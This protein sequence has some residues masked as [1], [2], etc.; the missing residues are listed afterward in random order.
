MQNDEIA[1]RLTSI[2]ATQSALQEALADNTRLTAQLLLAF[3]AGDTDG[4]RRYHESVIE[5]RELRN[6]VVRECLMKAATATT[7]G[8]LGWVAF[9]I[10]KA[11]LITVKQ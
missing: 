2:Q 3:P 9:A 7:L 11:L 1:A 6:K 4:H 10:W 5:W 8:A